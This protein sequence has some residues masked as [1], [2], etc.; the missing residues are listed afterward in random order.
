MF[1]EPL[2]SHKWWYFAALELSLGSLVSSSSCS[3]S[4]PSTS[5]ASSVQP[6]VHPC[7]LLLL[8]TG[9][10]N[11]SDQWCLVELLILS[12]SSSQPLTSRSS[13][14]HLLVW[15]CSFGRHQFVSSKTLPPPLHVQ[16]NNVSRGHCPRPSAW[17]RTCVAFHGHS[18]SN[19]FL[20]N[21]SSAFQPSGRSRRSPNIR[22]R[23]SHNCQLRHLYRWNSLLSHSLVFSKALALPDVS[24][25]FQPSL[26]LP[27]EA[28]LFCG[29]IAG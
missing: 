16:P 25:H 12:S 15:P 24:G 4:P 13:L 18:S 11:N 8:E 3:S 28:E 2:C 17:A 9:H 10:W 5:S 27:L 19:Q 22:F 20:H 23:S 26:A 6:G 21:N 29:I 7:L 14:L 1:W